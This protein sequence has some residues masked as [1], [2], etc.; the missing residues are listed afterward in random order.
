[1]CMGHLAGQEVTFLNYVTYAI[2]QFVFFYLWIRV[3]GR[4]KKVENMD[5]LA[6]LTPSYICCSPTCVCEYCTFYWCFQCMVCAM[7]RK[8]Q[9]VD[10]EGGDRKLDDDTKCGF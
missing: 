4:F 10:M 6:D 7:Y 3:Y 1:M 9:K 2:E 8:V 5:A